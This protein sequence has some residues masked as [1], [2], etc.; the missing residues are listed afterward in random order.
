MLA[1]GALALGLAACREFQQARIDEFDCRIAI[2]QRN[3]MRK[4]ADLYE[5]AGQT[6]LRMAGKSRNQNEAENWR[7]HAAKNF[8]GARTAQAHAFA[9]GQAARVRPRWWLVQLEGV[10]CLIVAAV[11]LHRLI[12]AHPRIDLPGG[13]RGA[14][15]HGEDSG[16]PLG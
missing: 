11:L 7:K 2:P 15:S 1:V 13:R 10:S 12:F 3:L 4:L 6:S 9:A 8:E 5:R 14:I 16:E